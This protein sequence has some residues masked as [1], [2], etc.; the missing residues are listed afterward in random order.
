[1]TTRL[2]EAKTEGE[3][4]WVNKHDEG[5]GG[6]VLETEGE[7]REI[8]EICITWRKVIQRHLL[9][10]LSSQPRRESM[11][12]IQL[13]TP[14]GWVDQRVYLRLDA[15]THERE[16]YLNGKF[17]TEHVGGYTPFETDRTGSYS[18]ERK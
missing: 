14:R 13:H 9:T 17:S 15:A 1:V 5:S 10:S 18:R 4:E 3:I 16:V 7:E 8:P 2:P 12:S 6:L 11:V